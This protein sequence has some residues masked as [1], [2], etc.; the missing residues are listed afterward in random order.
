[1]S[2]NNLTEWMQAWFERLLGRFDRLDVFME[3]MNSRHNVL[4]GEQLLDNQDLCQL[5]NISK[6]TLQ[7]Y[8]TFGELPYQ[9]IYHKTYYKESDVEAFIQAHF[10]KEKT[11]GD[12]HHE[13]TGSDPDGME[14]DTP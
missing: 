1:M 5:L 2:E 8:R 14:G 3:K 4:A 10:T 6:R 13:D 12:D 11:I 7:R 9:M